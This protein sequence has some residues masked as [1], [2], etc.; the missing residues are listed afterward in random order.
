MPDIVNTGVV[1]SLLLRIDGADIEHPIDKSLADR[2]IV[3]FDYQISVIR[4]CL[5][6]P[7]RGAS[8][9]S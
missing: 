5:R 6:F 9:A 2:D 7:F 3:Y 4:F 1:S 8:V